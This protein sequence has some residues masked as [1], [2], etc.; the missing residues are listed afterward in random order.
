MCLL[1][2]KGFVMEPSVS[3]LGFFRSV[4]DLI[5]IRSNMVDNETMTIS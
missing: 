4:V 5:V 2:A 3:S 1:H